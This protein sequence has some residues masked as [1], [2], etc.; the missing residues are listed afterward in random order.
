[1]ATSTFS[2]AGV[3][4]EWVLIADGSTYQ[5]FGLQVASPQPC[6]VAIST[7]APSDDGDEYILL[8]G[9]VG[10]AFSEELAQS[11]KVYARVH[12][13]PGRPNSVAHVRGYLVSR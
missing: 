7:S 5:R 6:R 10:L 12:P 2:V 9:T 1:M 4:D 3:S 13:A 11:D 8:G